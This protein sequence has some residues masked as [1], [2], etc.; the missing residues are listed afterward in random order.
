MATGAT[1]APVSLATLRQHSALSVQN[2]SEYSIKSWLTAARDSFE[3]GLTLWEQARKPG[4]DASSAEHAF[5]ALR[6]GA[7]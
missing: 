7:E 4:A 6:Q 1:R 3:R 2:P 5:V